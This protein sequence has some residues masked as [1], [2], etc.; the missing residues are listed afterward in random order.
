MQ[1]TDL[2]SVSS[3]LTN[4]VYF[5]MFIPAVLV[6]EK[7]SMKAAI[8]I[9]VVLSIAGSAL[10]LFVVTKPTVSI[11]QLI[12]DAGYPFILCCGTKVPARWFP[13]R[14][15]FLAT[16]FAVLFGL[17]GSALGDAFLE[18]F[19]QEKKSGFAVTLIIIGVSTAALI[20]LLF[21]D[22]PEVPPSISEAKK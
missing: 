9:G 20:I 16:S 3:Y 10:A 14:E 22:A 21:K 18:I 4:V 7:F 12:V 19:S 17:L 5:L 2:Y 15:R 1:D 13:F 8:I 11:G 6:I